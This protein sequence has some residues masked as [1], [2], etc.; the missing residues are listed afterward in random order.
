M[1]SPRH[2][3]WLCNENERHYEDFRDLLRRKDA[4]V[5]L[6]DSVLRYFHDSLRWVPTIIPDNQGGS[7]HEGLNYYSP[8]VINHTGADVFYR[9]CLAWTQL[10]L[11]APDRFELTG[12][13]SWP[14]SE[15]ENHPP[16]GAYEKMAIDKAWMLEVLQELTNFADQA[17]TGDFFIL[18]LGI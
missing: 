8:T 9:I 17:K 13:F 18:H 15:S 1:D 10:F 2:A 14:A 12:S 5:Q 4:P 11:N 3:F 16:R 7:T 6:P